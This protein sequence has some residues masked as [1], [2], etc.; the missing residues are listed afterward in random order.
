MVWQNKL[1]F[2]L[3]M[4]SIAYSQSDLESLLDPVEGNYFT[5]STFMSTRVINGH[6]IEMFSPGALDVRISHRFGSLNTGF[7]ELFG[8]DQATIRIG[9]EYGLSKLD[10]SAPIQISLIFSKRLL[11]FAYMRIDY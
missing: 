1:L 6:S 9:L 2:F 7:Y 10:E 8:L 5:T 11:I 4:I 3:C